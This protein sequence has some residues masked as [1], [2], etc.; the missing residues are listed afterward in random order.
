MKATPQPEFLTV[1]DL[2][3]RWGVHRNTVLKWIKLRLLVPHRFPGCY[4]V[5]LTEVMRFERDQLQRS[6]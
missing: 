6:T 3:V 2:T 5:S 1:T 4:R